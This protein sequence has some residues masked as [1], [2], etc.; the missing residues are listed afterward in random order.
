PML[1]LTL[2]ENAVKHGIGPSAEGGR[3]E[4]TA[5]RV[6]GGVRIVVADDGVG[7]GSAPTGGTG[8]GLANI[9]RQL[10]VR[11]GSHARFDLEERDERG[12]SAAITLPIVFPQDP[13]IAKTP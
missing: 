1:I 7:F 9:K 3:I 5:R 2:V 11:Y 8:V 13:P 4:I 10:S 12:V 6:R